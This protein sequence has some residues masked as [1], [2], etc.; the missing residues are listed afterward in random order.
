MQYAPKI[1]NS[2]EEDELLIPGDMKEIEE[3]LKD[4]DQEVKS[5]DSG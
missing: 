3:Q 4:I 5:Q 1:V 2:D